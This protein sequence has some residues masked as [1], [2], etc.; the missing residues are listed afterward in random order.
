MSN[1]F[2]DV[3]DEALDAQFAE[4]RDAFNA[5]LALDSPTPKQVAEAEALADE[6]DEMAAEI[7]ERQTA[8]A[9]AADRFAALK[10]RTFGSDPEPEPEVEA[11]AEEEPEPE[12]EATPEAEATETPEPEAE[13]TENE[14]E[15]AAPEAPVASEGAEAA[16]VAAATKSVAEMASRT[17][18]PTLP[19]KAKNMLSITAAH[20]VPGFSASTDLDGLADVAKALISKSRGFTAPNGT[21]TLQKF[22]VA[23]LNIPYADEDIV[24]R[25]EDAVGIAA[26]LGDE[27]RLPESLTASGWCSPSETVYDLRGEESLEGMVSIPEMGVRRGGIRWTTGPQFQDFYDDSAVGQVYT[28][29]QMIAGVTKEFVEIT[30]PSF[31]DTRLDAIP[32]GV[33]IP[34]L[35]E[36]AYPEMVERVVSGSLVAHQH[37]I[38][39]N[40][41]SRMVTIAGAAKVVAGMGATSTDTLEALERVADGERQR[42]RLPLNKTLEVVLPFW[43]KGALRADLSRRNG[44]AL[45]RVTDSD[46]T[47]HFGDRNVAVQFVYDWQSLP[48]VDD[49][50]TA[51][52]DE[53]TVYPATFDALIY[54]AGT[55]VKGTSEVVNISAV[56]DAA[57][58]AENTYTGMFMEQGLLVVSQQYVA[59]LLTL[60]IC[61]AGRTGA[62]DI[63]CS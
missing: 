26:R 53:R 55:Y 49:G 51:G 60:P 6:C 19:Q 24:K 23:S 58:L 62:A 46:I 11:A 3:T 9:T 48:L 42:Y 43:V 29:A 36:A 52:V 28:E 31:T 7:G 15:V 54:P 20:D 12:P 18:R 33:K 22:A 30:C 8:A 40:V 50:G 21:G 10:G 2:A 1:K 63:T 39:A 14:S 61:S 59:N 47:G 13:V 34:F 56:Y 32:F 25:P 44:I 5:I 16:P 37:K 41:I 17:K 38:N 27:S 57:S 45:A 4:K 35:L